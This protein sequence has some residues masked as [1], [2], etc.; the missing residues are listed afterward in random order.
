MTHPD[1]PAPSRLDSHRGPVRPDAATA[2]KHGG[3][4]LKLA[5][6]REGMAVVVDGG[7]TCMDEGEEKIIARDVE[8]N[9]C[10]DCREGG[11]AL[12]GQLQDDGSLIGIF[13]ARD[14]ITRLMVDFD[15]AAWVG[16]YEFDGDDA[17][18]TP[19]DAERALIEDAVAG[20]LGDLHERLRPLLA[21]RDAAVR[22]AWSRRHGLNA[23]GSPRRETVAVIEPEGG[24]AK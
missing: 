19:T 12:V 15:V 5:D 6:A 21:S 9:L 3:Q 23:D 16:D 4:Y 11:H 24:L 22:D 14:P 7:F 20:L 2:A 8:G 1:T 13:D 10:I 18:H 17:Y